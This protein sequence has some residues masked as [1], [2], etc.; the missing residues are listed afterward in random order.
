VYA[1]A[2]KDHALSSDVVA[3]SGGSFVAG[4]VGALVVV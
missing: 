2:E 3:G 1:A 4:E